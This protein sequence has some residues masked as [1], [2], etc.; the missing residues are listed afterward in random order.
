MLPPQ[1]RTI[2]CFLLRRCYLG[3]ARNS[4]P[5]SGWAKAMSLEVVLSSC[6]TPGMTRY[7]RTRWCIDG[8]EICEVNVC[9]RSSVARQP[10]IRFLKRCVEDACISKPLC[11]LVP[12]ITTT[13][14]HWPSLHEYQGHI[15]TQRRSSPQ[16]FHSFGLLSHSS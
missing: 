14:S 1:S 7:N 11:N 5:S 6:S 15:S 8:Q 16:L 13:S 2:T 4:A 3:T 10:R 9:D 12:R